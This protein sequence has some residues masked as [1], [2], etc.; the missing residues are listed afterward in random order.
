MLFIVSSLLMSRMRQLVRMKSNS[1][2]DNGFSLLSRALL[3]WL[4]PK[5]LDL[6]TTVLY[7]PAMVASRILKGVD[8]KSASGWLGKRGVG[9]GRGGEWPRGGTKVRG[10][11][12]RGEGQG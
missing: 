8:C 1:N 6:F 2:F 9:K 5:S 7:V 10:V 4:S 11:R 12:W 3:T